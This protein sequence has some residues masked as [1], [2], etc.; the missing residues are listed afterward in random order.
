MINFCNNDFTSIGFAIVLM[1]GFF[2]MIVYIIVTI[3]KFIK[4]NMK[5]K[6]IK[7]FANKLKGLLIATIFSIV[8]V[9]VVYG[10]LYGIG[11]LVSMI[12]CA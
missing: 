3:F 4:S 6:V 5:L 8:L 11:W 9:A 12:L 1:L 2:A 10:I 7:E